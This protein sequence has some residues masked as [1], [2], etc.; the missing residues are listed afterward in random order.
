MQPG[1]LRLALELCKEHARER[2]NLSVE[3]VAAKMGVAD[4]WSVYKWI[5]TG[6][7]PA[8]LIVPFESACGIDFVTRW[9]AASSGK[10][11]VDVPTGRSLKPEDVVGLHNGF[12]VALQL[13]TD[14][15]AGKASPQ[16]TIEAL[17]AHMAD[18][19]WHRA[20]VAQ[21]REPEL[22]LGP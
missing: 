12:G 20:N 22:D 11:V 1:N 10:L 14:F 15:Y 6:R 2:H 16:E 7:I 18:I 3:R 17:S 19:A 5:Q 8:N 13:L 21:H 9:L 4:H